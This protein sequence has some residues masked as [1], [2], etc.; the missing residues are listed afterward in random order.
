MRRL[1]RPR[2]NAAG[3]PCSSDGGG[4]DLISQTEMAGQCDT[5]RLIGRWRFVTYAAAK[6]P[7]DDAPHRAG[8]EECYIGRCDCWRDRSSPR[9][10]AASAN[11]W[12]TQAARADCEVLQPL[13]PAAG[14]WSLV[15]VCS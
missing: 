11:R 9:A 1:D 4:S 14:I 12:P 10:A 8:G 2:A 7:P 6:F 13:A 5:E 15:W 3:Y